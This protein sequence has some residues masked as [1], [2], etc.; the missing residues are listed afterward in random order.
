MARHAHVDV[1]L[2][3]YAHTDLEAM[4]AAVKRLDD[5]LD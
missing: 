4:R 5:E 1:T 3:I 2:K